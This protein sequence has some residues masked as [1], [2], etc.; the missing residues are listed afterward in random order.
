[1]QTGPGT[2]Q[3]T[4]EILTD[5]LTLMAAGMLLARTAAL[6]VREHLPPVR[7]RPPPGHWEARSP[8][9]VTDHAATPPTGR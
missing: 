7:T 9:V 2:H 6:F 5:A 1:M 3:I 8:Q 4:S